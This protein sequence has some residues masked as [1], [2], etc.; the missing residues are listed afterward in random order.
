MTR[1]LLLLATGGMLMRNFLLL[2]AGA[3]LSK[4]N[5]ADS[6]FLGNPIFDCPATLLRLAH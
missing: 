5:S 3:G 1:Q 2:A 6:F 4:P